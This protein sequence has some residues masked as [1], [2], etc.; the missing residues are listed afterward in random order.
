MRK[1]NKLINGERGKL[2]SRKNLERVVHS[3]LLLKQKRISK[4]G[5]GNDSEQEHLMS[6]T[7]NTIRTMILAL[8]KGFLLGFGCLGSPLTLRLRSFV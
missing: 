1:G 6:K 4:F 7:K 2:F 3:S 5:G 8:G